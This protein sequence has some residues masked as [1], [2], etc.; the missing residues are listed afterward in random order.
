[1]SPNRRDLETLY[2]LIA[3]VSLFAFPYIFSGGE[4]TPEYLLKRLF[5]GE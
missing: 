5:G 2:I 1:M 3:I 4:M